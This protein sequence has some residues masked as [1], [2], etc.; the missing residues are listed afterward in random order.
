MMIAQAGDVILLGLSRVNIEKLM[1]GKPI[2]ISA[3]S[4]GPM[5]PPGLTIGIMFGE[6]EKDI[7]DELKKV[8]VITQETTVTRDPRLNF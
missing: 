8:G 1:E 3:K 5:I 4:H 2:R 7:H 6:T